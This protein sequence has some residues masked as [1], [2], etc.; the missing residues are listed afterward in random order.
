M[1]CVDEGGLLPHGPASQLEIGRDGL[2]LMTRAPVEVSRI[3][4]GEYVRTGL[5]LWGASIISTP[6]ESGRLGHG[7]WC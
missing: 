5:V 7:K 1:D 3:K 6:P 4:V 2:R